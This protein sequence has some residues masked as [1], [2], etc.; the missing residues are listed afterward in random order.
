MREFERVAT[1]YLKLAYLVGAKLT[2]THIVYHNYQTD[3]AILMTDYG[4]ISVHKT[5]ELPQNTMVFVPVLIELVEKQDAMIKQAV[6]IL[7]KES[8]PCITPGENGCDPDGCEAHWMKELAKCK[9]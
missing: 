5:E 3:T 9:E 7:A 6:T 2:G 4:D 8:C 1:E